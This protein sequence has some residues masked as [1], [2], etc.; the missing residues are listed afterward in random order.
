METYE[1]YARCASGLEQLLATELKSLKA[2]R[3][4]PLK[5][6]VAFFGSIADAYRACLWSRVASRILLVLARIEA[7]DADALYAGV[8]RIDW[9]EHIGEGAS[10]AVYAHGMNDALRNTQFTAV[11]VKDAICDRLREARG[12]RPDVQPKRPDVAIDVAVRNAKATISLD[13]SGEPLHRRGYRKEGVQTDAPLKETL[14][15]G[16]VLAA[17]WRR[18]A[19]QGASFADPM[20]GSGTLVIEAAMIAADRA[21]GIMRD[22]WGFRGWAQH[23]EAV[24]G[25]LVDE[26]DERLAIGLDG[27]PRIVGTDLDESVIAIA[28]EN[29]KRAGFADEIIFEV[30]DAARL[31]DALNAPAGSRLG[32]RSAQDKTPGGGGSSESGLGLVAVNPPYGERLSSEAQLPAVYAALAEGIGLLPEGWKLAVITPDA[33]I[34]AALGLVPFETLSLYNGPIE[35]DLRLYDVASPDRIELSLISLSGAERS[36]AVAEKNSDQFVSRFRKVAKERMKWARKNGVSCYRLYDADLPDYAMAIDLYEGAGRSAGERFVHI[37]EYEAPSSV[38]AER[39]QR[40]YRDV[41]ALVPSVLD[42]E[43]SHVFSKTRRRDKGGG[44]YRDARGRSHVAWTGESGYTFEIDLGGYLDTGIFLDH[45]KT[46]ELVG[47]M[48]EGTRFLN[49][50]AYTGT[51]TVHAAGGRAASTVTVD[52]SQTYLSWAERNMKLNGFSG[53]NHVFVRSD[54]VRWISEERA[55]KRRYDLVFVD[56]PTFSNSKAMGKDTWSVQRDHVELLIGVSRLLA[57]GGR[58][59]F[60]CNLR[61]FKPDTEALERY[62][63]RLTDITTETIPEDFVRNPRIHKCYIVERIET[64]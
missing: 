2:Q 32:I 49:L 9:Q 18:M 12:T 41:L 15:A 34:D 57:R 62:G 30:A 55:S 13:L 56:P 33:A 42:V 22:Y 24:W 43:A 59:I 63:V 37:S 44:Q 39:A 29:A 61:S 48:A 52:L 1:F 51:A 16:I 46:R 45:R 36:V 14:A 25:D 7:H 35:A 19:R 38:D 27:M 21:P 58:A 26:A 64:A 8:K 20:C 3:V 53:R 28:R 31:G 6:G 23:D 47:S 4:R 17:G 10:I 40:R 5:G 11:K 50:F 60:S 54:V